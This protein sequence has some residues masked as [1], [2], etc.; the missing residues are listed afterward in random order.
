[1]K[2]VGLHM[3]IYD[4]LEEALKN[5]QKLKMSIL[6]CFLINQTNRR[7]LS[8]HAKNFETIKELVK[9]FDNLYIHGSYFIN[10]ANLTKHGKKIMLKE[11]ALAQAIGA[12]GLIMHSGSAT[13]NKTHEQGIAS[14]ATLL[15]SLLKEDLHIT[16]ILENTAHGAKSVGSEFQDFKK[17]KSLLDHPEKIKFCIDTAHA[18]AYGYDLSTS[19]KQKEFL[20]VVDETVGLENIALIHLN[21]PAHPMGS[22]LDKHEPLGAGLLGTTALR[23][24]IQQ[25]QVASLPIIL[26]LPILPPDEEVAMLNAI[27]SWHQ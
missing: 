11:L 20:A 1:M 16:I 17:I 27:R 12:S 3:R 18:H 13:E 6:Q 23:S 10:P 14:V 2:K 19:E 5:A 7:P 15:N 25:P 9:S 24:F 21:D 4:S 8:I 26:E 22:R